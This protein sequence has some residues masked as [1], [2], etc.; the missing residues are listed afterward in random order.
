MDAPQ[1][2][3]SMLPADYL[4]LYEATPPLPV[5]MKGPLPDLVTHHY[6]SGGCFTLAAALHLATHLP[7]ELYYRQG[8]PRHA[9]ITDGAEALDV[10][11]ARSLKAARA[12]ADALAQVDFAGLVAVV[13][14]LPT[15]Q[16]LADLKRPASQVAAETTA[17]TLLS[18][19]GFASSNGS[20]P[21]PLSL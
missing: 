19:T 7:I 18:L 14:S 15:P 12:G 21:A 5:P 6:S 9:Y 11:G 3:A 13:R 8:L 20:P 1:N 4:A 16:H 2:L 10:F 17:E